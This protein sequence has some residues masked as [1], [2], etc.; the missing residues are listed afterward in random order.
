MENKLFLKMVLVLILISVEIS[1]NLPESKN[2]S[3]VSNKSQ[4]NSYHFNDTTV[5]NKVLAKLFSLPEVKLSGRFI[6]SLTRHRQGIA[7]RI[8]QHPDKSNEYYIIDAGYDND[9]RFENYYNF[10]VWPEK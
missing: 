10:Y 5:E 8:V 9:L 1:W 4:Q 6:D 3:A 2:Y 7:M